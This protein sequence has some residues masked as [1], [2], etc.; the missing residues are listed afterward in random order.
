MG[1]TAQP[2]LG[3]TSE[4]LEVRAEYARVRLAFGSVLEAGLA[5][6]TSTAYR[7]CFFWPLSLPLPLALSQIS[8]RVPGCI[9]PMERD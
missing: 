6:V 1:K 2:D 3:A 9:C 8:R 7:V 4:R 5:G